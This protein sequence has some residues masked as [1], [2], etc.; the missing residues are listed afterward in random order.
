MVYIPIGIK[1]PVTYL[2][3]WVDETRGFWNAG[4][5]Y[6]RWLD[7]VD[8]NDYGIERVVTSS[9]LNTLIDGYFTMYTDAPILRIFLCIGLVVWI[10]VVCLYISIV[11]KDRVGILR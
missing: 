7:W 9:K 11:R 8:E 6:W 1:H 3:A 10:N 4:Y 5:D 2:T